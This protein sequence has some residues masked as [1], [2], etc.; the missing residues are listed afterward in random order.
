MTLRSLARYSLRAGGLLMIVA[1][2]YAAWYGRWELG[3]YAGDL[4]SDPLVR[5]GE[6]VRSAIVRWVRAAGPTSVLVVAVTL[7]AAA[8]IQR[9]LHVRT[10]Q[11][12]TAPD[13]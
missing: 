5:Q 13:K 6:A 9:A 12:E 10:A 11:S 8:A 3:V 2:A 1:G 4:S 7:V